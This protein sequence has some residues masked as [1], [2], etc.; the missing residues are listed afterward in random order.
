MFRFKGNWFIVLLAVPSA[1]VH[2]PFCYAVSATGLKKVV[3]W[4]YLL[5]I[6]FS[7]LSALF[8]KTEFKTFSPVWP[9]LL[10]ASTDGI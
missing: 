9:V 8:V 6:H 2:Y 5:F 3:E 1:N 7:P 10:K 4:H